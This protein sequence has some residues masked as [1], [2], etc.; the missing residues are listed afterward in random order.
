[1]KTQVMSTFH[2]ISTSKLDNYADYYVDFERILE[3]HYDP[4]GH[5][6]NCC[7]TIK[8]VS[9]DPSSL[10]ERVDTWIFYVSREYGNEIFKRMRSIRVTP[11]KFSI[12]RGA[13]A[14]HN[15]MTEMI[16]MRS[17]YI[18]ALFSGQAIQYYI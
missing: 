3:P 4:D 6:C 14:L 8:K 11:S 5:I 7:I 15:I 16:E 9:V 12:D 10:Q 1:M 2:F 17:W 18:P 13:A